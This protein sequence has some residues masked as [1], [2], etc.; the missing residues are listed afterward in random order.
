MTFDQFVI[1]IL[2]HLAWRTPFAEDIEPW[3]QSMPNS[4]TTGSGRAGPIVG[5]QSRDER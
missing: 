3:E 2:G 5:L 4:V 1:A